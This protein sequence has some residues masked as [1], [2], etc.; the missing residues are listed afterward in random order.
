MVTNKK[1][2]GT[3]E[4]HKNGA[5][6][7]PKLATGGSALTE[8]KDYAISY[9]NNKKAGTGT[10]VIK[11]KGNYTGNLEIPFRITV[12]DLT[13]PNIT[14]RVPNVPYTGKPNKYQSALV[15]TD[16]DGGILAKN[17]DY[18]VEA[19]YMGKTMLDKKSN[20]KEG[21]E[22]TVIIKGK[23][24]YTGTIETSYS[25]K[26]IDFSK[27]DIKVTAK[28]YTGSSVIIKSDDI[29]SAN[30]KTGK[31]KAALKFGIDYEIAA[32]SNNLKKGTATVTFKGIGAYAG[33]KTVK[34][35]INSAQVQ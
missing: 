5:K 18:A 24:N 16:S 28:R 11:G 17:K 15:L 2:I 32:Y 26:G 8:G 22:I 1:E 25:V 30:I 9:K 14:V 19:Y 13:S 6:P 27:A 10:I 31:T 29:I 34:F 4:I 20:P 35:K 7:K 12:K 23:G 21:A 33:E 3:V